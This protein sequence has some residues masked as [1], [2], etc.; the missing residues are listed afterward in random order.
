[1]S[2]EIDY[3]GGVFKTSTNIRWVVPI[4]TSELTYA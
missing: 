2:V 3:T 4:N 1:M